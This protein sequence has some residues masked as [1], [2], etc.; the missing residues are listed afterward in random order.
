MK[1]IADIVTIIDEEVDGAKNYAE[2]YI[3]QKVGG[4][5][6]WAA[7]YKE[8]AADELKHA[9]YLHELAVEK[10]KSF[11][12]MYPVPTDMQERWDKSHKLYVEKTAWIK[13]MMSM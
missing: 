3:E 1:V 11:E 8:M 7:K 6:E 10:I 12:N 5:T 2:S 4:D 9:M 13:Q